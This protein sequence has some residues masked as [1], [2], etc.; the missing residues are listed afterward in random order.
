[1]KW[2]IDYAKAEGFVRVKTSGQ[3]CLEDRKKLGKEVLSAGRKKHVN[4]FLLDQKD[5]AFG[6][7]VLEIDR[8]ALLLRDIGFSAKDRMAILLNQGSLKN[9][10]FRFLHDVLS[11]CSLKI[12]VFSDTQ[13]AAAWLKAKS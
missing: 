8:L 11:L 10:L 6:L 1:M 13:E 7:S 9:S 3:R 4:A 12:Q 2:T 5:T